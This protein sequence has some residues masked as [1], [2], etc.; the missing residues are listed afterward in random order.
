MPM[1]YFQV[2]QMSH[3]PIFVAQSP[4]RF[5]LHLGLVPRIWK[6]IFHTSQCANTNTNTWL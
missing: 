3:L 5:Q 1:I 2:S 6:C 4:R